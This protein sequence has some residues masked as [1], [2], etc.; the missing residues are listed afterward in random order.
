[1]TWFDELELRVGPPDASM[2][3]RSLD[4]ERWFLVDDDWPAQR[5]DAATLLDERRDDVLAGD[6]GDAAAELDRAIATW[7]E[8]HHPDAA[9][10]VVAVDDDPLARARR[11]VADDLCILTPSSSGW[12]LAAG[13]VC[14][15]SYWV[16]AE[17]VG[18]ALDDVHAPVPGYAGSLASRVDTF[19]GRLRP[20]QGVWRRNWSIHDDPALH[21]PRHV[22]A[23]PSG[24]RW[25]RSERQTLRRL[26]D[27]DA[28]VFT[29]RT[30]QVPLA[31]VPADVRARLAAAVR[32]WSDAVRAYKGGA[33]D[34]ELLRW[35]EDP[36]ASS[37]PR[38]T[39]H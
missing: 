26:V 21:L 6:G 22:A 16:L 10:A 2:G 39:F 29:I 4:D 12:V 20:G 18:R 7:L 35:L 5:A 34:D 38:A 33:V 36:T 15:P 23:D 9:V 25:L 37:P 24:A 8:A 19:L 27:N 1:M 31:A 28:V 3:T 13:A 11:R 14:F 17:K 32:G 30:Q